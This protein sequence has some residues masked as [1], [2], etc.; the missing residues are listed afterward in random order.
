MA[1][2]N[3][4]YDVKVSNPSNEA[5]AVVTGKISFK[6]I[7]PKKQALGTLNNLPNPFTNPQT[8]NLVPD[9]TGSVGYNGALSSATDFEVLA[10]EMLANLELIIENKYGVGLKL[11]KTEQVSPVEEPIVETVEDPIVEKPQ[12][13]PIIETPTPEYTFVPPENTTPKPPPGPT[14]TKNRIYEVFASTIE[15]DELSLPG[16]PTPAKQKLESVASV[17]YPLIKINDYIISETEIDYVNIDCTDFL[18]E[19]ALKCTFNHQSFISKEMP[20]DGDIISIAIRNKSDTL[21]MIRNDYVITGVV[22][23]ENNTDNSNLSVLTFFGKLF[24][25][26]L[27]SGKQVFSYE[28]T[29][30][31]AMKDLAKQTGLGFATNEDDTNDKQIWISGNYSIIDYINYTV[32]KSWKDDESFYHVWIDIYYNLNFVNIN[33]QLMS[34]EEEVDSAVLLDNINKEYIYGETSKQSE[35]KVTPKVLSNFEAYKTSS[36]YIDSWKPINRATNITFQ[37]GTKVLCNLYEHNSGVY[38]KEDSEKYWNLPIEPTYDPDKVDK[39]I[40]LR[41]RA[42]QDRDKKGKDL[43][44]ANYS[45]TDI[46]V[47]NAWTGIQYTISNPD[48]NISNWTGNHHKNYLRAGIQN[49]INNK[50]LDKLNVEVNVTGLNLNLI[51]G[52]KTPIVL[53]KT[54]KMEN[55]IIEPQSNGMD[56]LDQFYSGWYLVKGFSIQYNNKLFN[57][58]N[59]KF[60][61]TFVLTRREWPPP[62]LVAPAPKQT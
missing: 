45:Y 58:P 39:Y 18:P 24:I 11:E 60:T 32:S 55:Q 7:G 31:N 21:K 44:I 5:T 52:D 54:N 15:L 1:D 30:F 16:E 12:P 46:Y 41:G 36:F 23:N 10:D 3:T 42:K 8:G 61:Q 34:G 20:K 19:I 37:Y 51:R 9:N 59:S 26:G 28:G 38:S 47:K 40:L 13:V 56:M 4:I 27:S 14:N 6:K 29:S 57:Q 33:K 2:V 17:Q 25:P 53:I 22:S 50:E 43:A 35:T 62:I 49:V 48:D